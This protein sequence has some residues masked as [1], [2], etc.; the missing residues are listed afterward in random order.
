MAGPGGPG[1]DRPSRG[2]GRSKVRPRIRRRLRLI[3][4]GLVLLPSAAL[5][6]LLQTVVAADEQTR[7]RER[8][9]RQQALDARLGDLTERLSRFA[10][11]LPSQRPEQF[12]LREAARP[13]QLTRAPEIDASCADWASASPTGP[14]ACADGLVAFDRAELLAHPEQGYDPREFSFSLATGERGRQ[15][16]LFL[17]VVDDDVTVSERGPQLGAPTGDQLRLIAS[18]PGPDNVATLARFVITLDPE[19]DSVTTH[20]VERSWRLPVSAERRRGWGQPELPALGRPHGRWQRGADGYQLELRLPLATLGPGWREAEL[21]LAVV[22]VDAVS[23]PTPRS[24]W[25]VPQREG[26]FALEA[27]GARAFR[28]AWQDAGLDVGRRRLA[29]FDPR[30]RE[31]VA[32]FAPDGET[33]A[34]VRRLLGDLAQGRDAATSGTAGLAAA[35]IGSARHPL[36]GFAIE[37]A[38]TPAP[39]TRLRASLQ[40]HPT[41][42]ASLVGALLLLFVLLVYTRRLSRRILALVEDVTGECHAEDEIGELSRRLSDLI[43]RDHAQRDYLEQLPRVLAHET[44][45]PLAVVR[46]FLDD[47]AGEDR[48]GGPHHGAA[49]RAV[50]SI[51][52]LIEHL[53]EANSL[54]EALERGDRV[55]VDLVEHLKLYAT[56]YRDLN[57]VTLEIDLP[58]RDFRCIVIERRVEQLLDKLLDNAVDFSQGAPVRLALETDE[59]Q[60]RIRVENT[61]SRLPDGPEAEQLFAPLRSGRGHSAARHL[62]LGLHVARVI[63][64]HHG[65]A[66]RATNEALDPRKSR[67]AT[68]D[69]ANRVVFELTLPAA[70]ARVA[71]PGPRS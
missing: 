30:G 27:P 34:L 64:E 18:L 7:R 19:G 12:A 57:R 1:L 50:G 39:V 6:L 65:G 58:D 56:A 71:L 52:A 66:I 55:E 69:A 44:A 60:A 49:Q 35:R 14:D 13:A 24:I 23:G 53:R 9:E 17:R 28:R 20:Q 42:A 68:A 45:N 32:S 51:E 21:G 36:L 33:R 29:V 10:A 61:G 62:G 2:R 47:L 5:L 26:S 15:L 4:V 3:A 31:L 67:D 63:A 8:R 48:R 41:L 59:R 40:Q 22:D 11:L 46:M 37:A 38:G 25:V 70:T 16:Y 43:A 54:E